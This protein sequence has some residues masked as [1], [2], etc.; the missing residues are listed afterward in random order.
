MLAIIDAL[1]SLL[2]T[3]IL[4]G[5]RLECTVE[6]MHIASD[7]GMAINSLSSNAV[8]WCALHQDF[9]DFVTALIGKMEG[10][11]K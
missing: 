7:Q 5:K 9:V 11:K 6:I 8:Q 10:E 2:Q 3:V 4:C 1:A